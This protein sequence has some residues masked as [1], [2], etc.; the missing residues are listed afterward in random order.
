MNYAH[1]HLILNHFPVIG[2]II[3]LVVIVIGLIRKNDTLIK[4][5]LISF[6]LMALVT[7][8]V[9]LTGEPA[10]EIVEK[11]VG[12]SEAIMERHEEEAKFSLIAMEILGAISLFTMIISKKLQNL[13]KM[14]TLTAAIVA[15]LVVGMMGWT[16]NLGGQ[17]RHSEIRTGAS[18][19]NLIEAN[20]ATPEN[21]HNHTDTDD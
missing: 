18:S 4:T 21:K 12:T 10:E 14:L 20:K 17:I 16:A 7:I 5:G 1:L 3:G 9:F 6:I 11:V 15:F 2:T 19:T 13:S 8:P